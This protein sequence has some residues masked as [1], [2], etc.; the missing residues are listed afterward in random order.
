MAGHFLA[1]GPLCDTAAAIH[2][3]TA[4]ADKDD[5]VSGP[6]VLKQQLMLEED[7]CHFEETTQFPSGVYCVTGLALSE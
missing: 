5:F 1:T 4:G 2:T 3:H 6:L 7:E